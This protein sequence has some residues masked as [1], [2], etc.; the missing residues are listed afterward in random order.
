MEKITI[1]LST[2]S[3]YVELLAVSIVSIMEN[4]SEYFFYDIC[5]LHDGLPA[6]IKNQIINMQN[7]YSNAQISFIDMEEHFATMF[8]FNNNS[9]TYYNKTILYRLAIP[10]LFKDRQRVI[11]IDSDT[12]VLDNL[13]ELHLCS[14]N[15][16]YILS[17]REIVVSANIKSPS[18][19]YQNNV[20]AYSCLYS[21]ILNMPL[22]YF[23]YKAKSYINSGVLVF[24]IPKIIANKKDN[25]LLELVEQYKNVCVFIDQDILVKCFYPYIG[26]LADKYNMY[27]NHIQRYKDIS[28]FEKKS[29]I[30]NLRTASILHFVDKKKPNKKRGWHNLVGFTYYGKYLQKSCFALSY[31]KYFLFKY[32]AIIR[33]YI[34]KLSRVNI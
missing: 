22:E 12:V 18:I 10:Q 24:N 7:N 34:T 25:E 28:P 20:Y 11:Y 4:K 23:S 31:K 15:N 5:I 16:N 9:H 30:Q 17:K 29:Y 14:F 26:N 1:V 19:T 27:V 13:V 6:S 3:N 33:R 2:D 8:H 21:K 32:F